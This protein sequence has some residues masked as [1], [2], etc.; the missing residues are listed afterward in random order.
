M[1]VQFTIQEAF[2]TL[3]HGAADDIRAAA[4][5]FLGQERYA[6]AVP[7][8]ALLVEESD[9]GTRYLA[10]QALGKIGDEA[11]AAIPSLLIALR[12]DDMYLRMAITGTLIAI[13]DPAVPGL[14]KALF[15][16]NKAVRRAAAKALGKIGSP[17]AIKPLQVAVNDADATVRQMC[18]EALN[19]LSASQ[20]EPPRES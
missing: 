7:Y 8:L 3:Q 5:K 11:E 16:S 6:P 9:P 4:V 13:G 12:A 17:R 10:A 19:R 14:V 2:E 20:Q 15:D 1:T 18:E